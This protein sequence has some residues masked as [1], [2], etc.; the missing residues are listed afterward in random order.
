MLPHSHVLFPVHVLCVCVRARALH[1]WMPRVG[2]A[3]ALIEKSLGRPIADVF[4]TFD[5]TPL[6]VA[7]IGQ[8]HR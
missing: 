3:R 5:D 2:E 7:S 6:G 4:E 1:A 8:A